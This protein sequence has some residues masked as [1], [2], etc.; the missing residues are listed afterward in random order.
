MRYK[1]NTQWLKCI[2]TPASGAESHRTLSCDNNRP[3]IIYSIRVQ[4]CWQF[5]QCQ[6]RKVADETG[7]GDGTADL[8]PG[9]TAFAQRT[10]TDETGGLVERLTT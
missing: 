2:R 7:A 9:Q 10:P 3:T 4:T 8:V 5:A 6:P 1:F